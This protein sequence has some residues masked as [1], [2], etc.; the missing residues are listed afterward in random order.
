[1]LHVRRI[2]RPGLAFDRAGV[3]SFDVDGRLHISVANI[4][5]AAVNP[6]LGREIPDWQG[7]GLDPD[8]QYQLLRDPNELAKAAPTFRNLQI[9]SRHIPVDADAH[10]PDLTV[11]SV[12]SDVRFANPYLQASLVIWSRDAIDGIESGRKKEL[13]GAYRYD[14][15]MISGTFNGFRYDGRMRNIRGN[16]LALVTE[17]RAG[18]D[19]VVGDAA[20]RRSPH[21]FHQRFPHAARIK[22]SA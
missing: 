17:G 22:I 8:R 9:L 16:H 15:E 10:Q 14:A 18:P 4:S 11:G 13:S 3:R 21:D 6:Y 12:G 20:P 5:K 2:G 7:L 1:M 19:V